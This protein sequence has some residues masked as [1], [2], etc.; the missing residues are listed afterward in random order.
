[1]KRN[2]LQSMVITFAG[3]LALA[4]CAND[5]NQENS[6]R[7]IQFTGGIGE[8]AVATPQGRASEATWGNDDAIGIFMVAHGQ[9]SIAENAVNKQFTTGGNGTFTPVPG[10][11]IYFPVDGTHKVD[12][13]AYYPYKAGVV[14]DG[15]IDVN[16]ADQSKQAT[17]DLLWAKADNNGAG[18]NK[19]T[20]ATVPLAF[21]HKLAK[22]AMN[23]KT[24][25]NVGVSS[26]DG[27]TVVVKG[28]NTKTTF[29]V[30]DG[31]LGTSATAADMTARK[32]ATAD[33]YLASLD[34]IIL[35]GSYQA[36]VV[37]VEFT[38]NNETY[39]WN[40]GAAE[41]TAGNAYV[42]EVILSRTGVKVTGTIKPWN[43]I[44]K[45]DSVYAE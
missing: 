5:D 19:E 39:T 16:T 9:T 33:G 38:L 43:T 7:A 18:Y 23:C 37:T 30:K 2:K 32:I 1:M 21:E 12:F 15:N 35:P 45:V 17:F 29:T 36:G 11:E 41:F 20:P 28:M 3:V 24:D 8:Q 10:D 42:Y 13:I 6:P 14:L 31:T 40:V 26:L 27:M 4:S 44:D 22:L 25:P 34:A